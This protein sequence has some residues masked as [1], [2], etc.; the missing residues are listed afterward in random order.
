MTTTAP[1]PPD[2]I[3][4]KRRQQ[5]TWASGDFSAVATM[6][7]PVAETLLD[8][9][10]ARAGT[11]VLDVA[12][13]SGNAAMA[14]ARFGCEVTGVDYVPSLLERGRERAAAERMDISFLEGDA[15]DLPCGDGSFD[16]VVSV[17]GTMFA[18]DH[19]RTAA[20]MT[21]VC[22]PGGLL[23]LASWTPEGFLGDMFRT[24][25]AH[26]P[27]PAG[28]VSP[29][30]WGTEAHLSTIF[31]ATVEWIRHTRRMF[32]FRFTSPQAF[33][34]FFA[35]NYG[36]TLKAFEALDP[37]G[38]GVLANDLAELARR[39]NRLGRDGAIALDGEYLES[40]GMRR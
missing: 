32:T 33:V 17:F 26:V 28:I 12:T 11:T 10:D 39:H 25:G 27:P 2:L 38:R 40:V 30:M 18:P 19:P 7:V 22:R 24:I 1:P 8:S 16:A 4:I 14:A 3:A 9:M 34:D 37:A 15:E 13:G 21:R 23:G 31:E 20:E 29:M 35:T 36:P 5:A 6:I